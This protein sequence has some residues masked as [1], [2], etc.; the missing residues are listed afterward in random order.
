MHHS[1]VITEKSA[2]QLTVVG[3]ISSYIRREKSFFEYYSR[4]LLTDAHGSRSSSGTI[5]V[6]KSSNTSKSSGETRNLPQKS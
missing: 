2:F 3:N 6:G 1:L 4:G 5:R